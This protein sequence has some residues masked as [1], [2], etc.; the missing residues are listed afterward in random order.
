MRIDDLNE[1]ISDL[2]KGGMFTDFYDELQKELD[3]EYTPK[4]IEQ[5]VLALKFTY[6]ERIT[7]I[8]GYDRM[9]LLYEYSLLD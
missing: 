1:T 5:M 3:S 7:E 2:S 6:P 8:D 9:R 4:R